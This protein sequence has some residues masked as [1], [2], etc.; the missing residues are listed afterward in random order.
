VVHI[1]AILLTSSIQDLIP[2]YDKFYHILPE[3]IERL[4]F[5]ELGLIRAEFKRINEEDTS[6]IKNLALK[7][8]VEIKFEEFRRPYYIIKMILPKKPRRKNEAEEIL[9][10]IPLHFGHWYISSFTLDVLTKNI[11]DLPPELIKFHRIYVDADTRL[12]DKKTNFALFARTFMDIQGYLINIKQTIYDYYD[13]FVKTCNKIDPDNNESPY[14]MFKSDEGPGEYAAAVKELILLGNRG[15]L[16]GFPLIRSMMDVAMTRSL[17]DLNKSIKYKGK[18]IIFPKDAIS[19]VPAI[20]G[21]I[22]RIG[23]SDVFK[24]DAIIR[25]YDSLSVVSHRGLRSDEYITWFVKFAASDLCNHFSRELREHRDYIL[26]DLIKFN[27]IEI[28]DK[29]TFANK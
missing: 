7:N 23:L 29:E 10:E 11:M 15:R 12:A 1:Y 2:K 20:C 18:I 5:Q 13:W 16:T 24:T 6:T 26:D 14:Y 28:I 17:F 3:E 25:L 4:D 22:D 8:N 27:Q 9:E 19:S 21:A